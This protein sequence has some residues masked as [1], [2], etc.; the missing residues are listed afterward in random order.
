MGSIFREKY[1]NQ[2]VQVIDF[3]TNEGLIGKWRVFAQKRCYRND[4]IGKDI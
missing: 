2:S 3:G 4:V 1:F